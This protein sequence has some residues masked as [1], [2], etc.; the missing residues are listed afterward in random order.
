[1]RFVD[2]NGNAVERRIDRILAEN[3]REVVV[4]YK[5]GSPDPD[6]LQRDREQVFR[7]CRGVQ[8]ITG[9]SCPGLL[10]YI[11]AGSDRVIEVEQVESSSNAAV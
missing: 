5:S 3:G 10:W 4:D 6:R 11:D 8:Q 2:E 7:Y 9:R 1:M